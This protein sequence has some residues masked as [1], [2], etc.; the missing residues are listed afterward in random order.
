MWFI[1]GP[2]LNIFVLADAGGCVTSDGFQNYVR[3]GPVCWFFDWP[4]PVDDVA[5]VAH[6]DRFIMFHSCLN[7]MLL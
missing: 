5:S 7:V 6:E 2:I 3:T 4:L 1:R